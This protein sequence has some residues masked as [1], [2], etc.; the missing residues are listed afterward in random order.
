MM[1]IRHGRDR[2]ARPTGRDKV[3]AGLYA[4]FS[5]LI[6]IIATGFVLAA[7]LP[8]VLARF[9]VETAKDE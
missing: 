9:H 3:F 7:D 6:I 2:P 1:V 8:R 4:L 5:G